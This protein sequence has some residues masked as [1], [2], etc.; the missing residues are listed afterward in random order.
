VLPSYREHGDHPGDGHNTRSQ[1]IVSFGDRAVDIAAQR[2]IVGVIDEKIR[3]VV[4]SSM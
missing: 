3:L 4:I 2:Y 1:R